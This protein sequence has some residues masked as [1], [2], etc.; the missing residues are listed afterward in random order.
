MPDG[1]RNLD[2]DAVGI[3]PTKNLDPDA[4]GVSEDD[5]KKK[6]GTTSGI[7]SSSLDTGS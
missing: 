7:T 5:L 1:S 6:V 2:P 3:A 4:I